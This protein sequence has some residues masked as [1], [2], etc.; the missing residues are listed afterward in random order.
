MT[1][2]EK[3]ILY[4]AAGLAVV[5]YLVFS[6]KESPGGNDPTGNG[7]P[8]SSA[9][10]NPRR[11]AEDLR[12]AMKEMGTSGAEVISILRNVNPAQFKQVVTAFGQ[13]QYNATLG[14]QINFNPF[15]QLPF[16]NLKGWLK[17]ELSIS[18]YNTL[19]LKYPESL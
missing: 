11:V 15:S 19:K 2:Q 18:E 16:V 13:I 7:T 8:G 14:N 9:S 3:N 6:S 10:F 5:G 1:T 4:V 12:D 17:N